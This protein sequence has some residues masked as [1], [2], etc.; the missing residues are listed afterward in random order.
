[1]QQHSRYLLKLAGHVVEQL[2]PLFD[3][4]AAVSINELFK[5]RGV[6]PD[7]RQMRDHVVMQL[8]RNGALLLIPAPRRVGGTAVGARSWCAQYADHVIKVPINLCKLGH[9]ALGNPHPEV[10]ILQAF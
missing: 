2:N 6:C 3:F 1:M 4:G 8:A 10:T 9:R 5:T 7:T